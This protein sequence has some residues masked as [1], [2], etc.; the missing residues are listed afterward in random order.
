MKRLLSIV[1]SLLMLVT[2]LCETA[3]FAAP[4]A[5]TVADNAFEIG[6]MELSASSYTVTYDDGTGSNKVKNMP[7]ADVASGEYTVS[8]VVPTRRGY[9][10]EGWTLTP[11]ASETVKT[12]NVKKDITLYAKWGKGGY[13]VEFDSAK[14]KEWA[15]S[16][17][18]KI[19]FTDNNSFDTSATLH[20]KDFTYNPEGTGSADMVIG[21]DD[22]YVRLVAGGATAI[23][24][25]S[26]KKLVIGIRTSAKGQFGCSLFYATKDASGNW[27]AEFD[28]DAG[29]TKYV[30]NRFTNI[31]FKVSGN[32]DEIQELV[33]DVS[34]KPDL[35]KGY[36]DH[37]RFD[38]ENSSN[39]VGDTLSIDYIK[40][41]G[42]QALEYIDL[43]MPAPKAS[44][45]VYD[46]SALEDVSDKFE[47][48]N[49]EWSGAEFVDGKYFD[50]EAVYTVTAE[51]KTKSGYVFSDAPAKMT[52][53][54]ETASI[55]SD[56]TS[57]SVTYTFPAT[58]K[59]AAT[60]V[61]VDVKDGKPAEITES[62][63][64]LQL[65]AVVYVDAGD[66]DDG[67]YWSIDESQKRYASVDENG[68][69]TAN[70]DCDELLVTAT[71]KYD[72]S[73]KASIF[74]KI[75]GQIPESIITFHPGTGETVTNLPESILYKGEFV[76]PLEAPVRKNYAFKGWSKE[77]GGEVI[78]V[79]DVH[80]DTTY[81]AV[82]GWSKGEE[83]DGT[84]D[85]FTSKSNMT[86][87]YED[88]ALVV[89]PTNG[90]PQEGFMLQ[91]GTGI[92]GAR[93]RVLT[94][95]LEFIEI[96]TTLAPDTTELCCYIQTGTK[97]GG[98]L[99][100]W[101]EN[102]NT[103]FYSN[104]NSINN[105]PN[106]NIFNYVEK[107]GDW[108]IYKIPTKLLKNWE[109]Y[110]NQIRLNFAQRDPESSNYSFLNYPAG[111]TYKFDYI[112]FVGR[113]IPAMDI[114]DVTVPMTK[115]S[116]S[117]NV[118][119]VQNE[120]FNVTS[121]EWSPEP[122]EGIYFDSGIE[123][124]VSMFV[125]VL[126]GYNSFSNPPARVSVN[127]YDATYTRK[128]ATIGTISYTFPATED[129]GTIKFVTISLFEF[130]EG[131]LVTETMQFFS[132]DALDLNK[133]VPTYA[134]E[135]YRWCGWSETED[136]EPITEEVTLTS[137]AEFYAL[138]ELISE[139]D[140]ANKAHQN[141]ANV[142]VEDATL[143][144]QDSWAVVTPDSEKSVAKLVLDGMTITGKEYDYVEVIYDGTFEEAGFENPFNE[145]LSPA[146]TVYG[147]DGKTYE[148]VI[149]KA[150]P[151]IAS[152]R[153]AYKYTYD[154]TVN[155][156]HSIIEKV[157]LAPYTG[158]PAWA[159]TSVKFI[160]N[161]AIE[162]PVEIT[163]LEA[164][165]TWGIPD[166]TA[167]VSEFY[168]LESITWT[169]TNPSSAGFNDD[170]SFKAETEYTAAIIIKPKTGYKITQR[171]A[172][173]DGEVLSGRGVISLNTDGTLTVKKKF[174][175]TEKLVEFTLSVA[176]AVIDKPDG[177]VKLEA[178]I[179]PMNSEETVPVTAVEW[180]IVSGAECASIDENG[181]LT[182]YYNG[183]V[184]ICATSVYNPDIVAVATVTISNQVEGY[185]IKFDPN[186][187][188]STVTNMPSNSYAKFDYQLPTTIPTREGFTFAGWLE[189]PGDT[190]SVT[191]S[192][193][194]KDTTF[195]ALWVR[196]GMDYEFISESEN[197][198][199][200][201][202]YSNVVDNVATVDSENGVLK[203]QPKISGYSS[204]DVVMS[205]RRIDG[206]PLFK[207]S[208]YPKVVIR[209]SS[210]M[211]SVARHKI[212]YTS[213]DESGNYIV[214]NFAESFSSSTEASVGP[215]GFTDIVIDMSS[216]LGW[217]DGY[218]TQ[219]R[220]DPLDNGA[221]LDHLNSVISID[222]IRAVSYETNVVEITGIDAPVAKNKV[223]IDAVSADESK[224]VVT[225]VAWEGG[226]LYD[227]YFGSDTEY[228]VVV[229]VKGAPGYVVSDSPSVV[230]ING[231]PVTDF[232]YNA[233]TGE[234]ILRY[235][236][237]RT[238]P[239]T[240]TT[241]YEIWFVGE[242]GDDGKVYESKMIF[243]G[244]VID[245][246]TFRLGNTPDGKR[247]LGWS[248]VEDD[249]ESILD[250]FV[251]DSEKTFYGIYEDITEF[252]FSNPHHAKDV[253]AEYID[254]DEGVAYA[255]ESLYITTP[256]IGISADKYRF[257][258]VYFA[259]LGIKPTGI[260]T[261]PRIVFTKS[262]YNYGVS[263]IVSKKVVEEDG[264]RYYRFVFDMADSYYW[265]GTIDSIKVQTYSD[266][267]G[268][269]WGVRYIKFDN[270]IGASA[271]VI[272]IA[273]PKFGISEDDIVSTIS[274]EFYIENI[275]WSPALSNHVFEQGTEY[276][277]IVKF[278]PKEGFEYG[279][280]FAWVC[281][282]KVKATKQANGSYVSK[283]T[284]EPTEKIS[285]LEVLIE[286]P[287]EINEAGKTIQLSAK[288]VD[289]G[290]VLLPDDSVQWSI[291]GVDGECIATISSTGKITPVANGT[292]IVCATSVFDPTISACMEIV[293]TNQPDPFKVTFDA[294]TDDV[295]TGFPDCVYA[296]GTFTPENYDVRREGYIF[297]G[298]SYNGHKVT[299]SIEV[300]SD[301]TLH[302]IWE[303]AAYEWSFDN[304]ATSI[305]PNY[306]KNVVYNNGIATIYPKA[307]VTYAT[308]IVV[309]KSGLAK[310]LGIKTSDCKMLEIKFSIPVSSTVK[311][312]LQ[313]AT[314]DG[315]TKSPWA[316][317]ASLGSTAYNV[318]ANNPGEF[319]VVSF[320]LSKHT[321]WNM[322]P[323]VEQIRLDMPS[324][325][326]TEEIQIDYIRLTTSNATVKFDGNG[327][328]IS[329]Y[330]GYVS[331]YKESL[332]TGTISLPEDV[333]RE[334]YHF[335]GWSTTP[336]YNKERLFN[337][338]Y[339]LSSDVTL[340]AMWSDEEPDV[341]T[342]NC[343]DNLTWELDGN[344]LI[345]SGEGEMYDFEAGNAP[346]NSYASAIKCVVVYDGVTSIGKNAFAKLGNLIDLEL[347]ESVV[348]IRDESLKGK[349]TLIIF[350]NQKDYAI[351]FA[352]NNGIQYITKDKIV[353]SGNFGDE[354][355]WC[356]YSNGTL[357]VY[358]SGAVD[359]EDE[360]AEE[361]GDVIT[362]INFFE[363]I[364]GIN[365]LAFYNYNYL[366]NVY[367][368]S[369]VENVSAAS[370]LASYVEEYI[371]S[372]D[373]EIYCT[374]DFGAIYTSDMKKLV[375]YPSGNRAKEYSVPYGTTSLGKGS[376]NLCRYLETLN[377]PNSVA[378]IDSYVF[379]YMGSVETINLPCGI[380]Y[381]PQNAFIYSYIQELILPDSVVRI[382]KNAFNSC[383]KLEKLFIPR[384][385][386]SIDPTAF[387]NCEKLVIYGYSDSFAE[388]YA[389]IYGYDFV[390]VD[391]YLPGDLTG[392]EFV[393]INDAILLLQ[394]SMFPDLY[395]IS[396]LGNLDLTGDGAIDI[397]D[398]ILL[399]QHSMFPD[400]YPIMP[401]EP[402]EPEEPEDD[403]VVYYE[404][405][406]ST[407]A[408]ELQVVSDPEDSTNE[409][410]YLKSEIYNKTSWT[411]FWIPGNFKAGERYIV[412]FDIYFDTDVFGNEIVDATASAGVCFRYGDF[413]DNESGEASDH[414]KT[415]DG[416]TSNISI[417][418]KTWTHA[419]YIYEMPYT[420][421]PDEKML[422]GVF[423]NP[424][425]ASGYDYSLPVNFYIDNVSVERYE[426]KLGNGLLPFSID[427][428]KG[429][430]LDMDADDGN[431]D[432]E[433][434][435][436]EFKDGELIVTAIGEEQEDPRIYYSFAS[437][438]DC[439]DYSKIAIKFKAEG[440]ESGKDHVAV[441]YITEDDM[442][443]S[444]SKCV[445]SA[446]K[447]LSVDE[448]GYYIALLDMGSN[449]SWNGNLKK[450]RID[451]G[452]GN[453]VYTVD[454][455]VVIKN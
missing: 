278:K 323:Y 82:W 405:A 260:A 374:D 126:G 237:P 83:F 360:F 69:V 142:K 44:E 137:D 339:Y 118:T 436:H 6:E 143:K 362:S 317:S 210:T 269:L 351:L 23:N 123:Y 444:Q 64:T 30:A 403:R 178:V 274:S 404:Y 376:F 262:S 438:L 20:V 14:V 321:N 304:A 189:N 24:V 305:T 92:F 265:Y 112:R 296:S 254:L 316:E 59:L 60:E 271:P 119:V 116:A 382:D 186:T 149:V 327:G 401:G 298:W 452:N 154:L 364:T 204:L 388:H 120:A 334:G 333:I 110:L 117:S 412:D 350:A 179:T 373:N 386:T 184:T 287:S 358:G 195:Y 284:F 228:T 13:T 338:T 337:D 75:S 65:E 99:T 145:K 114:V 300:S 299:D 417:V 102:A 402:E 389:L 294:N 257:V 79:D 107:V 224:Y 233:H 229:T 70:T 359:V 394:Y 273:A 28:Q 225:N 270:A 41:V 63:G 101:N 268:P 214:R 234:L 77:L 109:N 387:T 398:A 31:P 191:K 397:N 190:V 198:G 425:V 440:V 370:F 285:A 244:D 29:L 72:P 193:I 252:D 249:A 169:S 15:F 276:S 251:V 319:Q 247:F 134:P 441:Y 68:L 97:S 206:T 45:V 18:G 392:D 43:E 218:I 61:Y 379:Y 4:S 258:D 320:D 131:G 187:K 174:P 185:L 449:S 164:P 156:K 76:L 26:A 159:V 62:L 166:T 341:S 168:E 139:F 16:S 55:V 250:T 372:N 325:A 291:S 318:P 10:F 236:F 208:D 256:Y 248:E 315:T 324:A 448:D 151:V 426:G 39:F 245:F 410:Y 242:D 455:V 243:K 133:I 35:W 416:K 347:P 293:I 135:G 219:I 171:T 447:S 220:F 395:P 232:S 21:G 282:E 289:I 209:M 409:V 81:Y 98:E 66:V 216:Q 104:K 205:F 365:D 111:E 335:V 95:D 50:D 211:Y 87:V 192:Y 259:D 385:V 148:A 128:N 433:M 414:G 312:Y 241:A 322:Y 105:Y 343:G 165:K 86:S 40:F 328:F 314:A 84:S 150:E 212:Y 435:S 48:T 418:P 160:P 310:S 361:Y 235:T 124:T 377:V 85:V 47:V 240:D 413:A 326:L 25:D 227:Y 129:V 33:I 57:A 213:V 443:F 267:V 8:S 308:Q 342:N 381:I 355:Y 306:D 188:S 54:G 122:V 52:V 446:Y 423:A 432:F 340:Y 181:V 42:D 415:I 380:T 277:A 255:G 196:A 399:L 51:L 2:P 199:I 429:I 354:C 302:A 91:A 239:I 1:L 238:A 121:V 163:G 125:E 408:P 56:G 94:D 231:N 162:D 261:E 49:L 281:G 264:K 275:T 17:T 226:L 437:A 176:D 140:F 230:T 74:I 67:V 367:I 292:A 58:E 144:F 280:D 331:S 201:I 138:Y 406:H 375:V 167:E 200:K 371:V 11:D 272:N 180:S 303:N 177:T 103:R 37:F 215:D 27:I 253:D 346:W 442:Y 400:L 411:Y 357:N 3:V 450:I 5:V 88:G 420:L 421:N 431:F 127:G 311:F 113:D 158:K 366:K 286:G 383:I 313:S 263:T 424:V 182:A 290:G 22:Y 93:N 434:C 352:K 396:Y 89:T 430:I 295:V 19:T 393:D 175:A 451:P 34:S 349:K 46:V 203:L 222:Y 197:P 130:A 384:S 454:K 368:S 301:I 391:A 96:K 36:L 147:S 136:G 155:G 146:L 439:D 9:T 157:V 356:L 152:N 422:F 329:L 80:E 283:V 378:E 78:R 207:G 7:D 173:F 445:I 345:I 246:S 71:S 407:G 427:H 330:D 453:G 217:M 170:G 194:T 161:I 132:G 108:Y 172:T 309:S 141:T 223:D 183:E 348:D 38:I 363:G 390:A 344:K 153:I 53:N 90:N 279:S 73:A 332:E 297:G 221:S 115:G 307:D 106:Q 32:P 369:T 266:S 336:E 12:V 100:T 428:A 288:T 353:E 419:T 202:S